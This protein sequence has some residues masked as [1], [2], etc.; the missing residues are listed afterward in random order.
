MKYPILYEQNANDFSTLGLG[1]LTNALKAAVTEERNGS[2]VFEGTVLIDEVIYPQIQENGIIKADAGH[3]LKDQR[4]RIKRIVDQHDG[5]AAIY[6]EHVSYI[7]QELSLRPEASAAGNGLSALMAWKNA[8]TDENPLSVGSDVQ[9]ISKTSWRIDK[10]QN[11]RQALGGVRGS[12]LDR[13]GGEYEFDNYQILLHQKRGTTAQTLIAYGRNITD[14]EQERNI[15]D[16]YT[17]IYPYAIFKPSN[18]EEQLITIPGYFVDAENWKS[19]PNRKAL[20]VDFSQEFTN[21]EKPTAE[22]L[23]DLAAA[24][25]KSNQ[26]G[27]PKVS[28]KV[29][30]LDLSKTADYAEVAILEQVNLCDD[31]RVLYPKLGV[32]TISQVVKTVWNVLLEKYDEL[33]IGEKHSSLSS[34]INDQQSQIKEVETMTNYAM[35]SANG[36]NTTFYGLFGENGLGEPK[37]TRL[38]DLWYR[39]NGE[40]TDM[41]QWDGM[42]WKLIMSTKTL[43]DLKQQVTEALEEA[44]KGQQDAEA[45]YERAV[46][47]TEQ[48]VTS[49]SETW[50]RNLNQVKNDLD[51]KLT[52]L[53]DSLINKAWIDQL[54]GSEAFITNLNTN[55]LKAV[56]A[57]ITQ[58]VTNGLSA[59]TI[60]SKF[61]KV[62]NALIDKVFAA[63]GFFEKLVS[64]T[65]FIKNLTA[66]TAFVNDLFANNAYL[67]KLKAIDIDASRITA[68]TLRTIKLEGPNLSI[69]LGTGYVS[70]NKGRI[71][72]TD[73]QSY[74]DLNGGT[75]VLKNGTISGSKFYTT[76]S[77]STM[78]MDKCQMTLRLPNS[79]PYGSYGPQWTAKEPNGTA[80]R[81]SSSNPFYIMLCNETEA[82]WKWGTSALS[83]GGWDITNPFVTVNNLSTKGTKNA[84]HPTRDGIR[85]TPAYETAESYLGDIGRAHTDENC[86]VWVPI[87]TLFSDTVN[88]D[89]PYEVFLQAYEDARFWVADF[90][91]DQFLV[92]SDKPMVRFAWEI[93]AKRRGYEKDRLVKQEYN[94]DQVKQEFTNLNL[95]E[96]EMI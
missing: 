38:G 52:K 2:F 21:E 94:N 59:E 88:T 53:P 48:K 82:G 13:W 15:A 56:T 75:F 51:G 87:E 64:S 7:T 25:I 50:S 76:D 18:G 60:T 57:N 85:A 84:I 90:R 22:K 3:K 54:Y 37:A 30:F 36:K 80:I 61:I 10:V 1:P 44:K 83:V 35:T 63:Q 17:S 73:G 72:T 11:A 9:T 29:S 4:F 93:K 8:I 14:F 24:Y 32:E 41:L 67:T 23:A 81:C 19:F 34:I 5:T 74:L 66:S 79:A 65:A 89:I 31:V 86:A 77:Y 20:P 33:E 92:R 68:G 91:S 16:T 40:F 55:S 39:P 58:I 71:A 47:N 42:I 95:I 70:M 6:A 27:V 43:A 28:I 78:E 45:A 69:D 26:I 62:D 12:I 46:N 96:G 49:A